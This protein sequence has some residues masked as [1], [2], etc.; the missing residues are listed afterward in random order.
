MDPRAMIKRIYKED[1]YTLLHT[2]YESSG[3][4]DF[5]EEFTHDSP[6]TQNVKAL[7]LVV[8]ERKV[9]LCFSH[10]M[11]IVDYDPLGWAIFDSMGMVGRIY[12]EDHYTL[13]HTK[14]KSSGPCGFGEEDFLC[15]SH[16]ALGAGPVWTPGAR[17][18]GFIER[19]TI[20][21]YTQN[22]KAL[23][24]VV[25]EKKIFY[26][27]PIVCLWEL[28]TPRA[29]PFLTPGARLAGFIKRTTT[30]CYIQ[31]MKALGL[32]VSEKKIFLCFNHDVPGAGPVWT[33]GARLAGFIEGTTIHCYTKNM[34]VLGLVVSVKIF[35]CTSHGMTM[36][37]N[38]PRGRDM[39]AKFI[40]RTT[41]NCYIQNMKALGLVVLE[42]KI[43]LCFSHCKSMGAICCHGNQN[44]DP[45]WP[46][47]LH[48]LSPCSVM[49]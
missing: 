6:V 49:L 16:D 45:T 48:N 20:H 40:K 43:C 13:L 11:S 41:T 30:N 42:K 10:C 37:A 18:A 1:H 26:V 38:D 44:Y 31:N 2:K 3:P 34:K 39:V 15:F 19:T 22:I 32:V 28:M 46:K 36:G 14:Y 21:C 25:S 5:G 12:K 29:G 47:T 4:C 23:G 33:P 35:L 9:V 24:L 27:L 7:G 8:S 17:L